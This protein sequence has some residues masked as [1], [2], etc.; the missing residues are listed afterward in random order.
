MQEHDF[1]LLASRMALKTVE[2]HQRQDG[3]GYNIVIDG[4]PL[5]SARKDARRFASLDTAATL[6]RDVGIRRF[7]IQLAETAETVAR[8]SHETA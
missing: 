2:I 5:R 1:R 7:T 4:E 8:Q 6:L 3:T